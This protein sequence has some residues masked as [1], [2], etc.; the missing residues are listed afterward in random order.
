MAEIGVDRLRLV[1]VDRIRRRAIVHHLELGDASD[2][3]RVGALLAAAAPLAVMRAQ[4]DRS[5]RFVGSRAQRRAKRALERAQRNSILWPLGARHAG[6]DAT[7]VEID[8]FGII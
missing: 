3:A 4:L 8:H 2:R 6:L 7:Q 5:P 1:A